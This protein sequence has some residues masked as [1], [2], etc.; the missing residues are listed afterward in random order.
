[1]KRN[2]NE[3]E[4]GRGR[5]SRRRGGQGEE[6]EESYYNIVIIRFT[7]VLRVYL[8]TLQRS[9]CICSLPTAASTGKST[10]AVKIC[11]QNWLRSSLCTSIPHQASMDSYWRIVALVVCS[12]D[13]KA[14]FACGGEHVSVRQKRGS[15][16]RVQPVTVTRNDWVL[17]ADTGQGSRGEAHRFQLREDVELLLVRPASG[18]AVDLFPPRFP[19]LLRHLLALPRPPTPSRRRAHFGRAIARGVRHRRARRTDQGRSG[20][21]PRVEVEQL[22][23]VG[24]VRRPPGGDRDRG[25][26]HVHREQWR[27]LAGPRDF[28]RRRHR[29]LHEEA[30]IDEEPDACRGGRLLPPRT[31]VAAETAAGRTRLRGLHRKEKAQME[32]RVPVV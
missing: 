20:R 10:L 29:P 11:G 7:Y 22:V 9:I 2:G 23:A 3:R 32:K 6:R 17:D 28:H 26:R 4:R 31:Y 19:L 8:R 25:V 14:V 12:C 1:M 15:E 13:F 5:G 27:D 21:G 16:R 30:K 18:E 24:E